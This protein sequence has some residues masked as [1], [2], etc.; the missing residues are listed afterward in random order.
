VSTLVAND[1][2]AAA[3]AWQGE[4]PAE[5]GFVAPRL[6][7]AHDPRAAIEV[8]RREVFGPVATLM[9]YDGSADDAGELVGLGEGSLVSSVYSDDDVFVAAAVLAMAPFN[10]RVHVGTGDVAAE[11]MG[12][13]TVL[14]GLV[15]GGPGRAGSGEELGGIRGLHHFMQRTAVQ[16]PKSALEQIAAE[17]VAPPA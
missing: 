4:A 7:V 9:P 10:G 14:P 13:G 2:N 8:H 16:G 6:L 3:V 1:G 17:A 11:S 12:P 15:H 5:H